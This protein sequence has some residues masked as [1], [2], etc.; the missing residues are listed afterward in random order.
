MG[1][2]RSPLARA[3]RGAGAGAGGPLGVSALA[4]AD[5]GRQ[6]VGEDVIVR[7]VGPDRCADG[8]VLRRPCGRLRT[9][10]PGHEGG[11]R[12]CRERVK[13]AIS[14]SGTPNRV[15]PGRCRRADAA[16]VAVDRVSR[17]AGRA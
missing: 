10:R 4:R 8:R 11:S 13:A 9:R 2:T 5:D 15:R 17:A 6:R 12:R 7:P 1:A 3:C 14:G 16:S